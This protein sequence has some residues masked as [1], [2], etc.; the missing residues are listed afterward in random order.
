MVQCHPLVAFDAPV[1]T[2]ITFHFPAGVRAIVHTLGSA[3]KSFPDRVVFQIAYPNAIND[4]MMSAVNKS[5]MRPL[6]MLVAFHTN[7]F[8]CSSL[9]NVH[10]AVWCKAEWRNICVND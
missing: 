9:V 6:F 8:R 4:L 10:S 5:S 2:E 7:C 1:D 3:T